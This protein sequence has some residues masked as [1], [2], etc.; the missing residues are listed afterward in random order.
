[1][2]G[3]C[4]GDVVWVPMSDPQGENPKPR[5]AVVVELRG[6]SACVVV[7]ITSS[8]DP[9]KLGKF[10]VASLPFKNGK[11]PCRSGLDRP[12]VAACN[13]YGIEHVSNCRK[14]G[15]LQPALVLA[16]KQRLLEYLNSQTL[17]QS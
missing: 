13:W 4:I 5:T 6:D 11:P 3:L 9:D 16:I 1:M 17:A 14:V 8:F 12:S 7:A 2:S 10:D 15:A